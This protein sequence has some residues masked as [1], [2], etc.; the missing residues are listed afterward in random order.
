VSAGYTHVAV[1]GIREPASGKETAMMKLVL[2]V[3]VGV[4][5]VIGNVSA[6]N[7]TPQDQK[8]LTASEQA[9]E[10]LRQLAEETGG[11]FIRAERLL[12]AGRGV[13][14]LSECALPDGS[15]RR[16]NT[17]VTIRGW[18]YQCVEVLDSNLRRSGVGWTR[19]PAAQQ[20]PL[21]R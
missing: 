1:V 19:V 11:I 16:V 3:L 18:T 10:Q 4:F 6:Q 15:T 17:T 21:P 5:T 8:T 13:A 7:T 14:G 9:E 20:A 12:S 2:P